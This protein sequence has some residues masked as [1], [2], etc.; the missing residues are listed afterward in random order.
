MPKFSLSVPH[1][2]P[3]EQVADKLKSFSDKVKEKF[4]GTVKDVEQS[5]SGNQ[6]TFQFTTLGMQIGGVLD[7]REKEVAVEGDLP[8]A[9]SMFKG[10]IEG[11][12]KE[13]LQKLLTA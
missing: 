13:Q 12:I 1:S 11:A 8:F 2:Y 5:W 6:M 10:K 7:V 3:P 4:Q 9:A